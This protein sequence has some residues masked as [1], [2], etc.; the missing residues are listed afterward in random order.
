MSCCKHVHGHS[1]AIRAS[2]SHRPGG[3]AFVAILARYCRGD[4]LA[5][6]RR[7]G[8]SSLRPRPRRA[9]HGRVGRPPPAD[10]GGFC[11]NQQGRAVAEIERGRAIFFGVGFEVEKNTDL[12]IQLCELAVRGPSTASPPWNQ[13]I[14]RLKL[15][16]SCS[17][18]TS[19]PLPEATVTRQR[20]RGRW[21]AAIE[22][23]STEQGVALGRREA[24]EI[25]WPG[26][27]KPACSPASRWQPGMSGE[28]LR[29]GDRIAPRHAPHGADLIESRTCPP[30]G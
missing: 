13:R 24:I 29:R 26:V 3:S 1:S 19:S 25:H 4:G 21:V 17:S 10:G 14:A 8:R 18:G 30:A 9:D 11:N 27:L 12:R 28:V 6:R 20:E 22:Q 23:H 2:A 16:A 5:R 7:R 15:K